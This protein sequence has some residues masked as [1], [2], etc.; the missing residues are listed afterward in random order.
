VRVF[1]AFA[2]YGGASFGLKKSDLDYSV[3][4][5]SEVDKFAAAIF[6]LNHP[7]IK[8]FGDITNID[9][10]ALPDFD[11]F[12]GGFPCQPFSSAGIGKGELDVR[13]TLFHDIL[14][15]CDNKRPQ[16]ILLENVRGL[17]IGK[18][19]ATFEKIKSELRNIGYSLDWK[20]LNSKNYGIPQNRV[21]VWIYGYLGNLPDDFT[22]EPK[23]EPLTYRLADFL[24]AKPPANLYLNSAQIRRLEELHKVDFNVRE[25]SC[26]DIYNKKIRTDGT[27]ITITEPHHNSLRVVHP[28]QEGEFVV[29]K[30]SI[31]EH[32]RLMGFED[33]EFNQGS[34]S[35]QQLCK[36]AG[37]GWDV[38]LVAK[39]FNKIS[40]Q[41]P[42]MS[43]KKNADVITPKLPEVG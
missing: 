21:R 3:V 28:P 2:G 32:Y 30:L 33:G 10:L 36:R 40:E 7:G 39:I 1:E 5:F 37:N 43:G 31:D 19:K 15:I 25:P 6:E 17:T 13:G 34:Q 42:L 29:R 23:P 12:T 14:R 41:V 26:L 35:Y 4:G 8:N 38:S 9:P 11:L 22:I 27:C 18:H 24:D 20:I 16:H